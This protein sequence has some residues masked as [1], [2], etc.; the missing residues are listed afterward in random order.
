MKVDERTEKDEFVKILCTA[1]EFCKL[2][3]LKEPAIYTLCKQKEE[4][5]I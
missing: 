4:N 5:P 2:K 1:A 3:P